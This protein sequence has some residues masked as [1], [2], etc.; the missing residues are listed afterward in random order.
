MSFT[1]RTITLALLVALPA[2]AQSDI[3]KDSLKKIEA[4]FRSLYPGT[5][6]DRIAPSEITGV[7]EVS[8]GKNIAYVDATGQYFI[9]GH[10]YDMR[11]QRDLT[12]ERAELLS[13]IDFASLPLQ[14][15]IK[16]VRGK[17]RRV[18]A[19]FS[20]PDCPYCQSLEKEMVTLNDVTVYTFLFPLTALHPQSRE[21]AIAIWCAS[22]PS[23]AWHTFM[24][25]GKMPRDNNGSTARECPHP[26]ER[27]IALGKKLGVHGTPTLISSDGRVKAGAANG[28]EIATW[29]DQTKVTQHGKVIP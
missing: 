24:I 6:I 13:R 25:D 9:F 21:H 2:F 23:D 1:H 12:A 4:K 28:K 18:F 29:L 7:Y 16:T 26:M 27:N 22:N 11:S 19:V 10:L 20:D 3:D 8:M 14:D 5:Q 17:G 15:A